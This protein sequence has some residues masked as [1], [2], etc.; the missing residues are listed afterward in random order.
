[1]KTFNIEASK[2]VIASF[3]IDERVF[4]MKFKHTKDCV[5]WIISQHPEYKDVPWSFD[6]CRD[7]IVFSFYS[8]GNL[9]IEE[10]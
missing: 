4:D 7:K 1:M 8:V 6:Y 2:Q 3:Q 5:A 9:V 10:A